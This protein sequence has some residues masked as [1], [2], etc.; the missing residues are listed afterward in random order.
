[1]LQSTFVMSAS[2]RLEG[3]PI[4]LS[5]F[6]AFFASGIV[7]C[8]VCKNFLHGCEYHHPF[9]RAHQGARTGITNRAVF[10]NGTVAAPYVNRQGQWL[11]TPEAVLYGTSYDEYRTVL[12]SLDRPN[13]DNATNVRPLLSVQC[14]RMPAMLLLCH[15]PLCASVATYMNMD[16]DG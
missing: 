2:L 8:S 6:A 9:V 16:S 12:V 11:N 4:L 10:L 1:M 5:R 3:N 15:E 7:F 14:P 13:Y